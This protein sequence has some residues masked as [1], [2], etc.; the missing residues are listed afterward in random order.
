[1]R[2]AGPGLLAGVIAAALGGVDPSARAAGAGA[3]LV[4][5]QVPTL[6]PATEERAAPRPVTGE[7]GRLVLLEPSGR[8]RVLTAGFESATDPDVSFDGERLL[9]SAR[10]TAGD[11]W[12]V[13]E[14][15]L[16]GGDARQITCGP[17]GARQP[18]Y[19]TTIFT[20]TPTSVE[21]WVQIAFV[22]V[23]PGER[24]EAGVAANTSLWSCKTDGSALRRLTYNLSND[25]DPAVL[26]DGR[27]VYAGWLFS[28]ASDGPEGRVPLLGIGEDGTDY[29]IYAGDEGLRVKRSP[30]PTADGRVV[31]VE[32][33][34]LSP[35]GGGRLGVVSQARPL[36]TYRSLTTEA[37]GLFRSPS[38]LPDGRLLVAWR[39][40]P[41]RGR[42]G[43]YRF[44]PATGGKEKVLEDPAW[45][46]V[47][48]KRVAPRPRP[49]DRSSV[50]RADDPSGK[51]YSLDVNVND[52][53]ARLARGE[54]RRLRLVEG[55]ASADSP[56]THRLL[57]EIPLAPDGS[58]QVQVP[59]NT[60]I[61][62]QLLDADGLA[63]RRSAWLWV[64]N[65]GQ[66]GCVGCHED[67]ERTP[68]NRFVKALAEPAPVLDLAPDK[69]RVPGFADEVAPIVAAR[70]LSC[71]GEGGRP[72]R[73]DGGLA[74]LRPW[75][76]PGEARR[77]RVIWHLLGRNTAR[78][79]DAEAGMAAKPLPAGTDPPSA[80]EI[81][82]F[83]EWIDLGGQP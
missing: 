77:S 50:V 23:D 70:C 12:C 6:G 10:R 83:V 19:Q 69:R 37:D 54:A 55:V 80:D 56:P 81:Q 75:M 43:I 45:H 66:Q 72:P 42:F 71:H 31:F 62:L 21:P 20:I 35:D 25:V 13:Y 57:G 47:G 22:G 9:F 18:V 30:A 32:G 73:L 74:S 7:G 40:G 67:P 15:T 34:G 52:L 28:P 1:M 51:L 5:A 49:D 76:V 82:A 11:P 41:D 79:W 3:P 39:P 8:A 2:V 36:H 58:Y 59:A 48:A 17:A 78:P 24:D 60:P 65:H 44:D 68:P 63:L 29:Q 14:M 64:R 38:P 26:P 53:G 33:E 16:G 46:S 61:Q 4:V 27:M